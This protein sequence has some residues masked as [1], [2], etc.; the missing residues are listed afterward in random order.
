MAKKNK[1]TPPEDNE[2]FTSEIAKKFKQSPGLYIGSVAILI[3]VVVAFVG[4]DLLSGGRFGNAGTDMIFGRYNKIPVILAPGN[5][6][7]RNYEAVYSEFQSNPEFDPNDMWASFQIW[8]I[9][10]ERTVRDTAIMDMMKRSKFAVPDRVIDRE[11][12]QLS[13]FQENGRFN[14]ALYRATPDSTIQT[15]RRQ[16]QEYLTMM[17][18][19]SDYT[20]LVN[21][22]KE[23]EFIGKM[24]SVLRSF[25]MVIF[26]RDDYPESEYKAFALANSNLFDTIG[27]SKIT[28]S[29]SEREAARILSSIKE[30]TTTFEDAARNFSQDQYAQSGGDM[31]NRQIY[32]LD[33]E[34]PNINDRQNIYRL[35]SGELSGIISTAAG[36]VFYRIDSARAVSDFDDETVMERVRTYI[37]SYQRGRMEDWAIERANEFISDAAANGFNEAA[38]LRDMDV[39]SFGALPMNYGSIDLFTSLRSFD[40]SDFSQD[41][42]HYLALNENFWKTAFSTSVNTPSDPLVYNNFIFVFIPT[43]EIQAEESYIDN[44]ILNYSSWWLGYTSEQLMQL[45]FV[46][47][48]R[49]E[50]GFD[51]FWDAF[52]AYIF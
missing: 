48:G 28:I 36:W 50:G 33:I 40:I 31:G 29:S 52:F 38:L 14:P 44:I 6:F 45:Y 30:G 34:I 51:G 19:Y 37:N 20:A 49:M 25:D 15:L 21:Y 18:Y 23:A 9:A 47:S 12:A 5:N 39:Y 2:S 16:I 46:N 10:F 13:M 22:E 27:V 1:K 43:E 42:L 7:A 11:I 4:G 17:R 24:T 8:R 35:R 3:L 32:L 41:D 26:N